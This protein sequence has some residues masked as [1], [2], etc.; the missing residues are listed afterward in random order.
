MG[1]MDKN[2]WGHL[3][4]KIIL[5]ATIAVFVGFAVMV[6]LI[7]KLSYNRA[8]EAGY[9]L[10]QEQA[11]GYAH[12]VEAKL[13]A[14]AQL[15]R[16]LAQAILAMRAT[17]KPDRKMADNM[18]LGLLNDSQGVMGLW[19]LWEP[20]AFDNDDNAFRLIWPKQDPTGRYT[21]Y[22]TRGTNG[23]AQ[24]DNM[25]DAPRIKELP[26]YKDH[27][28]TYQP[29][30]EKPGW[31]DFYYT[32]KQRQRD[33]VTEPYPYE[34]GGVPILESSLVYAIKDPAGKFLGVA[35]ADLALDDLQKELGV[36]HPYETGYLRLVS[37]GG[38]YVVNPNAKVL[39]KPVEKGTELE[40]A[41]PKVKAGK[42]FVFESD[43]YTHFFHP[44]KVADTGQFWSL[45]VSVPTA[46]ITASAVQLRNI[47][48][49]IGLVALVLILVAIA[50]VVTYLTRPLNRLAD[51]M[52]GLASGKGDL[53]V[54]MDISN[55][56]E[57]GRTADAFNRFIASLREM[58]VEVR[59][60]S[61]AVSRS[62]SQLAASAEEVKSSSLQ[63]SE[64]ASA[65][66]AG[67]EEVTVSVQH[68]ADT[69][70]QAEDLARNTGNLTDQSVEIVR[71][72]SA[73]I[74]N[75]TTIMHALT[76]RMGG[77]GQRSQEVSSI[78]N[79]IRDIADQTN[80]LAL[81]AAIEAARAGEQGRGFAVVADEVRNLAGRTAEATLEI[82]RIVNAIR[83]E[84]RDAVDEVERTRGL[85]DSSVAVTEEANQTM[86]KV[87]EHTGG[88]VTRMVDIASATREQSS[89]SVE[90]A[91][92]VERISNMA[93]SNGQVV[94]EVAEA[95]AQLRVLADNL[96]RLVG[97]FRL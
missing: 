71:K 83:D 63:Q 41:L 78:V 40:A 20:N 16:H 38:L 49:V 54:R 76:E 3:R 90:I 77:L 44:I 81:N 50:L 74:A 26:K 88:L 69:A 87:S 5:V 7:A 36:Q 59:E 67:V 8:E 43:G 9:A 68:I 70:H 25:L 32:P 64:A 15:P 47:A 93:Q 12:K 18:I 79:V 33:T 34:V 96:E 84:T 97:N 24:I 80:L 48:I 22:M 10:A 31:G 45:G 72:V 29:D 62:A 1:T 2:K 55:R 66:A 21:P 11:Q 4:T 14:T 52:E 60:Q 17:T 65:T 51:T 35:A 82:T 27:P 58:F 85:V 42:D 46:A 56:D 6:G 13:N 53:T 89:A 30:Y 91:Q 28:E 94:G 39:G 86:Y 95:V 23:K 57:I 75:V 19:T 92:N 73:D 37:E 61:M